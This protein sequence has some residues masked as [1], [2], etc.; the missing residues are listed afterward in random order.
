MHCVQCKATCGVF[1]RKVAAL[2]RS[3]FRALKPS[4]GAARQPMAIKGHPATAM[5]PERRLPCH[6]ASSAPSDDRYT[7]TTDYRT[8]C[9]RINSTCSQIRI[10]PPRDPRQA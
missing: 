1:K 5:H 10:A 6:A 8:D 7:R 9:V 3:L 2:R 4:A